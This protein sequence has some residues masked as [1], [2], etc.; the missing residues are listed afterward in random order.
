MLEER[1]LELCA[2]SK[3]VNKGHFVLVL[4]ADYFPVGTRLTSAHDIR[5]AMVLFMKKMGLVV[6]ASFTMKLLCWTKR[7]IACKFNTHGQKSNEIKIYKVMLCIM[8]QNAYGQ[9]SDLYA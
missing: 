1:L 8:L 5:G 2:D 6:E 7:I 4:K 9:N 3:A